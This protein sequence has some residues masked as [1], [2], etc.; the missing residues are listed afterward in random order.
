MW[1]EGLLQWM[2]GRPLLPCDARGV[3]WE[4]V[5]ARIGNGVL[6]T[7]VVWAIT[8]QGDSNGFHCGH[9]LSLGDSVQDSVLPFSLAPAERC[10][11]C[12]A[13]VRTE[14]SGNSYSI[15]VSS[16]SAS[17]YSLVL[18]L[19]GKTALVLCHKRGICRSHPCHWFLSE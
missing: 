7:C 15:Y 16:Q 5:A 4:H 13:V 8:W 17:S 10:E 14:I 11:R 3:V 18:S 12:A 1:L 2:P 19:L 9:R 6:P